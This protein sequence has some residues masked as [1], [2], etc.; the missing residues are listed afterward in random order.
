MRNFSTVCSFLLKKTLTSINTCVINN[1]KTFYEMKLRK[2]AELLVYGLVILQSKLPVFDILETNYSV[3]KGLQLA[4]SVSLSESNRI[5]N[6]S[7]KNNLI[8]VFFKP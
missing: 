4:S 7:D 3:F 2:L 8:L 1:K 5:R 6:K